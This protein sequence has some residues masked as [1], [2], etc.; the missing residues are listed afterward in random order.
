M[1]GPVE[2]EIISS[3][4]HDCEALIYNRSKKEIPNSTGYTPFMSRV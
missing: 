2:I 1:E 4:N 3:R